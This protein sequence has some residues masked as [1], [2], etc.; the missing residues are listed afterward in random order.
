MTLDGYENIIKSEATM[1]STLVEL[2]WQKEKYHHPLFEP[3]LDITK[4]YN[5]LN[6]TA[7]SNLDNFVDAQHYLQ[8]EQQHMLVNNTKK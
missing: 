5:R 8:N 6:S 3:L 7:R 1:T 2:E 4:T